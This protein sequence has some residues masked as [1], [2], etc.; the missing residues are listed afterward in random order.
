MTLGVEQHI[1]TEDCQMLVHGYRRSRWRSILVYIFSTLTCGV[2]FLVF[3][4]CPTW[5]LY[6][7]SVRCCFQQADQV[8][9]IE[10]YQ[11]K[12]KSYYIHK[13]LEKNIA[14]TSG[15]F[16]EGFQDDAEKE[17]APVECAEDLQTPIHLHDGTTLSVQQYRYFRHKKQN[18]I[19][20]YTRG[21]WSL[22]AGIECGATCAQLQHMGGKPPC[23]ERRG[24]M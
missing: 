15:L 14:D 10:T 24:R 8:L 1:T 12:C 23:S 19:W 3:H 5:F 7:T 4:W 22:L 17:K 2:P 9:V 20:D 16:N 13:I 18:L 21:Q 11:K 6:A